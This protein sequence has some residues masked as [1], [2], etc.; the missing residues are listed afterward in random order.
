LVQV[1]VSPRGEVLRVSPNVY[2][3]TADLEAL[4]AVFE[5]RL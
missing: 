2:N 3:D 4:S 5:E 1:Y